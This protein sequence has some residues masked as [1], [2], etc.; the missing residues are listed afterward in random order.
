MH[1]KRLS[2]NSA[3]GRLGNAPSIYIGLEP[4][5]IQSNVW[6]S[7]Q[8]TLEKYNED[9]CLS[10]V[11][12]QRWL[13]QQRD[14]LIEKGQDVPRPP[15]ADGTPPASIDERQQRVKLLFNQLTSDVPVEIEKRSEAEAA[16][17]LM[18][19]LLDWHRRE[20]KAQWW[21]FYRLAELSTKNC[22]MKN[23][24]WQTFNG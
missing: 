1:R 22:S 6:P 23:L 7:V 4:P 20:S 24:P 3:L 17:W 9:D 8:R 12:L 2:N 14:F 11:S 15:A 19:N 13:E 5:P 18:A 16:R 10:L 21:E